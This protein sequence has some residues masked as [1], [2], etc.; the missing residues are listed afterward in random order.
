MFDNLLNHINYK[1]NKILKLR[2][3]SILFKSN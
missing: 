3:P 2:I 1:S